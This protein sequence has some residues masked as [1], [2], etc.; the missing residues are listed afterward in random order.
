MKS[1][2]AKLLQCAI[3]ACAVLSVASCARAQQPAPET[4]TASYTI[5]P[6]VP[7]FD[8][9]DIFG[10]IVKGQDLDGWI[11]IYG[12]GNEDNADQAVEWLRVLSKQHIHDKGI[13]FILIGDVSK[14][15]RVL[16]P[17]VRKELKKQYNENMGK[18]YKE[19]S[20]EGVTIDYKLED[21]CLMV[22]DTSAAFFD[23]FGI[24]GARDI[25]HLFIVDGSHKVRYHFSSYS[26]NVS[27]ALSGLV[28]ENN[29]KQQYQLKMGTRKRQMWKRYAAIGL[30]G[31][32]L[33]K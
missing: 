11:I 29:S 32:F 8:I 5:L 25:P 30:L 2:A 1:N 4:A 10:R 24:G 31:W 18:M 13:L 15:H 7:R 27:G 9:K 14:Y 3:L 26:D 17:T 22:A 23:L 20:D 6:T 28:A 33:L 21:R 12:F 19:L 16:Q